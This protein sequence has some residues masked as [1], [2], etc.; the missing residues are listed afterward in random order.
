MMPAHSTCVLTGVRLV[1]KVVIGCVVIVL[2]LCEM[3]YVRCCIPCVLAGLHFVVV[4][5]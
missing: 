5:C 1:I 3:C 4:I 2:V